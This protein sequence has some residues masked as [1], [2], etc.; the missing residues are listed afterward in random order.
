[1]KQPKPLP[2]VDRNTSKSASVPAGAKVGP[3]GWTDW[4]GPIASTIGQLA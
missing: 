3:S 4:I 1:M 2:A